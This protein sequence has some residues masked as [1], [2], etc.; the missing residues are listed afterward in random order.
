MRLLGAK[1]ESAATAPAPA[2]NPAPPSK[3]PEAS[4]PDLAW[5]AS[6]LGTL[7]AI[8][9][10]VSARGLLLLCAGGAF[11]LAFGALRDPQPLRL[12]A[13]GSYDLLVF[14]PAVWLASKRG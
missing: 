4:A 12:A 9:L 6:L 2:P 1:P 11:A 7:Q 3:P 5:R 8:L 13:A 14:L 10:V